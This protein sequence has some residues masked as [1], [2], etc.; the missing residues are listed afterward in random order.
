MSVD[1]NVLVLGQEHSTTR[2]LLTAWSLV[3]FEPADELAHPPDEAIVNARFGPDGSLGYVGKQ[4]GVRFLDLATR[5]TEDPGI[6]FAEVEWLSF[7]R[8]RPRVAV[9]GSSV[10]VLDR[11]DHKIVW[12]IADEQ[13]VSNPTVAALSADGSRVAARASDNA[14]IAIVRLD[15]GGADLLDGAIRPL[16]CIEFDPTGRF[17]AAIDRSSRGP[18]VW[19][20]A[21]R[22]MRD[23]PAMFPELGGY[24]SLA[25]DPTG[26]HL[27]LGL[28]TGYVKM[29]SLETDEFLI[30]SE[31][32]KGRVW[33]VAFGPDG[34]QLVS[35][36]EDGTAC[37]WELEA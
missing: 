32:H 24:W 26:R 27:A 29:L 36:S 8:A 28:L 21:T 17:L 11:E 35:A 6:E 22:R 4:Q 10:V 3:D 15:G 37:I 18:Y 23:L 5:E 31:A 13:A 16:R 12:S 25:F 7:A 2:R 20:L 9:S 14:R 1:G 19:D 33:D 34:T 30:W